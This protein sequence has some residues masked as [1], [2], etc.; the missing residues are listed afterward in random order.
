MDLK[1]YNNEKVLI[2]GASGFIGTHLL[3]RLLGTGAIV[4]TLDMVSG[5]RIE[6]VTEYGGDV[7][8]R[9][10]VRRVVSDIRPG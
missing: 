3:E 4:S 7:M 9:D 2:T 1:K 10:F 6:G 5:R 8:N